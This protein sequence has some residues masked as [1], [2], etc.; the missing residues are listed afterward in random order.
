MSNE[1]WP[2][3]CIYVPKIQMTSC[4][5]HWAIE[6]MFE[7]RKVNNRIKSLNYSM[8]FYHFLAHRVCSG[9]CCSHPSQNCRLINTKKWYKLR[10]RLC[11]NKQFYDEIHFWEVFPYL[12]FPTIFEWKSLFALQLVDIRILWQQ[13]ETL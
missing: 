11:H 8:V 10:C 2:F 7:V 4:L 3:L 9:M 6:K 1:K 5:T 13:F 12:F